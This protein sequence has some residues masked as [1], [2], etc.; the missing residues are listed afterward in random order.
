MFKLR[1]SQ[2]SLHA[3]THVYILSQ[4]SLGKVVTVPDMSALLSSL[5]PSLPPFSHIFLNLFLLQSEKKQRGEIAVYFKNFEEAEKMYMYLQ[6]DRKCVDH[7]TTQVTCQM[8]VTVLCPSS[9]S[10]SS[11]DLA[12]TC[13]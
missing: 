1:V 7:M 2:D 4:D 3:C 13:E 12:T 5:P 11:R 8:T 6:M 9:S 10:S